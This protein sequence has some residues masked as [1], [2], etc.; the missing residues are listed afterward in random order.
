M[1]SPV[2]ELSPC[3]GIF[4]TFGFIPLIDSLP[5][6][7]WMRRLLSENGER[8]WQ[9]TWQTLHRIPSHTSKACCYKLNDSLTS[10]KYS[11]KYVPA[12]CHCLRG[13][14][15]LNHEAQEGKRWFDHTEKNRN[16][17]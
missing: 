1:P 2:S 14:G 3:Q 15:F 8:Q 4:K 16:L 13:T 7:L 9:G 5:Q 11:P 17:Q 12:L 10:S 6:R